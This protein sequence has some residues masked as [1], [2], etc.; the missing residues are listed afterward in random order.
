MTRF[1]HLADCHL[2]GWKQQQ[3]QD[4]N[5]ESFRRSIDICI[6]E[7]VDFVVIA[8]DL[9]DSAYPPIEILKEAFTEFKKLKDSGTPCFII[10]GS[11]D[12][13]VSG[14]TFL[15]VLE[16]A[17]FCK[18]IEN[19]EIKDEKIILNPTVHG[20]IAFYGYPGKRSGLEVQDL[21]KVT[22]QDS[23][24]LFKIF[25]LHT[26]MT[27]VKGTLPIDSV[28]EDK[29]P[30]SDYYA[31]GHIHIVKHYGNFVYPGP[32][33]PNNFQELEDLKHGGFFIVDISGSSFNLKRIDIKIKDVETFN[34]NVNDATTATDKI[35]SEL[36]K[37]NIEDKIVLLRVHGTLENG[38]TSDIK[39]SRIEDYIKQ[40]NAYFLLRNTHDLKSK[41]IEMKIE[42]KNSENIEDEAIK[43]FSLENVSHF[44]Q[45]IP[46]LIN[47]LSLEKHEDEKT[48]VF[49]T[50]LVDELKKILMI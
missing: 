10:A 45:L 36:E 24:G 43:Q 32:G 28:D 50:R 47:T 17:G 19:F 46:N 30:K 31:L 23:P 13:S 2:G 27:G 3:L 12:S 34:I 11:H 6:K 14:K 41:D 22:F 42:A 20:N 15:D 49:E 48:N 29:L 1:A 35:I 16:R 5:F 26:T 9:F 33:F 38:K 44:N 37:K 4:L 8:G 39:F 21:K 7:K 18:N 40:R 25:A